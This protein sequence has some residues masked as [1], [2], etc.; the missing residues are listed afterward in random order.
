MFPLISFEILKVS[1]DLDSLGFS[2]DYKLRRLRSGGHWLS[3][4]RF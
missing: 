4:S 2:N 1:V 3:T